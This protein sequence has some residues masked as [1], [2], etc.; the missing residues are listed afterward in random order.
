VDRVCIRNSALKVFAHVLALLAL[1]AASLPGHAAPQSNEPIPRK[2]IFGNPTRN[3]AR[4]SPDGKT[5]AWLAPRAARTRRRGP[6]AQEDL[7]R[8][9]L[10]A[11]IHC[12]RFDSASNCRQRHSRLRP[13][14]AFERV[15]MIVA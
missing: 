7:S 9:L 10:H 12:H 3:V 14:I 15:Q 2:D 6:R 11:R 8:A 4:V 1:A 5:L 13:T